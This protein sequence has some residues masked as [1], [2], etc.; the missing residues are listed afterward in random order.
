ME[1]PQGSIAAR[2]Y[3]AF[4]GHTKKEAKQRVGLVAEFF[5]NWW[6]NCV[7]LDST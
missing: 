1:V 5:Q 2:N 6:Q 4:G 3:K 7:A